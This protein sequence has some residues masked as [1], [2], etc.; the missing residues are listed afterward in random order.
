MHLILGLR[1]EDLRA[2][3]ADDMIYYAKVLGF[4][5]EASPLLHEIKKSSRIP[6]IVKPAKAASLLEE[7]W[8]DESQ[9][10]ANAGQMLRQD[11]LASH[12]YR[13]ILS[14]KYQGSFRSEYQKS[15]VILTSIF[16]HTPA[17]DSTRPK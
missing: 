9:S 11:F 3:R 2:F 6:L 14:Y 1:T 4:R 7:Y 5:S 13:S 16:L 10:S 17:S 12:L 15:P 8:G